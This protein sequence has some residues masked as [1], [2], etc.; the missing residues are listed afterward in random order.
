MTSLINNPRFLCLITL[1]F[2]TGLQIFVAS[3]LPISPD[4]SYYWLWS[5]SLQ[6]SYFDHP[7]MVALWIWG[8]THLIPHSVLA[9]RMMSLLSNFFTSFI[10]MAC[11]ESLY[12]DR[13]AGLKSLVLLN[14]MLLYF[15]AGI[16]AT[17][18]SPLIFFWAL[19]LWFIIE[20]HQK[21]KIIYLYGGALSLGL[22]FMSKYTSLFIAPSLLMSFILFP[23]TYKWLK[24]PHI[25][26]LA[27]VFLCSIIPLLI[28]NYHHDWASFHKQFSHAFNGQVEGN[29][30]NNTIRFMGAQI[31]LVGPLTVF[32]SIFSS[33]IALKKGWSE[34]NPAYFF[35]GLL[36]LSTLIFFIDHARHSNVQAH[37]SGPA[38]MTATIL[39]PGFWK[40]T[41]NKIINYCAIFLGIMTIILV[42]VHI[43]WGVIAIK[44]SHDPV[45]RVM[46]WTSLI[47]HIEA[48]RLPQASSFL[49]TDRHELAGLISFYCHD[50][51][52][53]FL[54]DFIRPA[55]VE[56]KD[57]T[58]LLHQDSLYVTRSRSDDVNH[59]RPYFLN[60]E[61]VEDDFISWREEIID[62]YTI[63]RAYDY[64]GGL[65][66]TGDKPRDYSE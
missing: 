53:V 49:M 40:D 59:I 9:V 55:W 4:E 41:K 35:I 45:K 20:F 15:V 11:A 26:G 38:W 25:I 42:I 33:I 19:T 52:K 46:G 39:I 10:V 29:S 44:P 66:V 36:F 28:W 12:R 24:F 48:L 6:L 27:L 56:K 63:Y 30:F 51:P 62:S 65:L 31:G 17:P 2:F 16:F 3:H 58:L 18:D 43:F 1:L 57:V 64:Q 37:W 5:R 54:T 8:G 14:S 13:F 60:I 34:K 32:L 23:K 50:H 7:P 22:A 47:A 21:E 61:K